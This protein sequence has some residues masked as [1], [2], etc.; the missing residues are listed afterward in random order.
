M[1]YLNL[2]FNFACVKYYIIRLFQYMYQLC[3]F[4]SA[5]LSI[6]ISHHCDVS[7]CAEAPPLAPAPTGTPLSLRADGSQ[8]RRGP[9]SP[10]QRSSGHQVRQVEVELVTSGPRGST[11]RTG[12]IRH[13]V[14]YSE[15]DLDAVPLRCYRET[16]LDEVG[17]LG[18]SRRGP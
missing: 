18:Q 2:I 3:E 1:I 11:P 8:R 16:D 5:A 6:L 17:A 7:S 12:I 10:G 14:K 4:D 13:S 9:D 15:T